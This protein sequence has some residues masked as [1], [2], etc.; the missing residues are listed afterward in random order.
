[1]NGGAINTSEYRRGC[2][3]RKPPQSV[4]RYQRIMLGDISGVAGD[5]CMKIRCYD[6]HTTVSLEIRATDGHGFGPDVFHTTLLAQRI[7][8]GEKEVLMSAAELEALVARITRELSYINNGGYNSVL[9]KLNPGKMWVL[10]RGV[11]YDS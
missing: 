4:K 6:L 8:Q 5:A 10:V 1:M 7:W 11:Y 3:P 9:L 2:G